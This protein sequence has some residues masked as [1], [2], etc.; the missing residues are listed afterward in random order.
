MTTKT[1][2]GNTVVTGSAKVD[3]KAYPYKGPRDWIVYNA[4]TVTGSAKVD[5]KAYNGEEPYKGPGD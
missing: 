1:T 4:A 2:N 3:G 5:G